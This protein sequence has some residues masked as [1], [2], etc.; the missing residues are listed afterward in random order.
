MADEVGARFGVADGRGVHVGHR[1]A[2]GQVI[3]AVG[4]DG[5]SSG[6]HLQ[7]GVYDR[8]RHTDPVLFLAG[9]RAALG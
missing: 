2:A 8:G 4:N 3:A 1:V 7:L 5:D 6:C 9:R